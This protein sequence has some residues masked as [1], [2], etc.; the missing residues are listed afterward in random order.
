M[1]KKKELEETWVAEGKCNMEKSKHSGRGGI[2]KCAL[3]VN[4]FCMKVW[5]FTSHHPIP[6]P[7]ILDFLASVL[8]ESWKED[9]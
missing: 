2:C 6:K 8:E 5:N 7:Q 9:V 3:Q 1:E 4:D